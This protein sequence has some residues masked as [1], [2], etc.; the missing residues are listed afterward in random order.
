M[1]ESLVVLLD[2]DAIAREVSHRPVQGSI[3]TVR[4]S[5]DVTDRD[6][7]VGRDL[8]RNT[9]LSNIRDRVAEHRS[10]HHA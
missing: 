7:G 1:R 5:G 3:M 8:I 9:N 6:G 10:E 2:E 4:R